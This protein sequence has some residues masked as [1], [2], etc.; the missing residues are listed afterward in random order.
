MQKTYFYIYLEKNGDPKTH[1]CVFLTFLSFHFPENSMLIELLYNLLPIPNSI[2]GEV[3]APQMLSTSQIT[4]S[5][6]VQ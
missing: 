1:F 2:S 3:L 5:S 6:K 4:E